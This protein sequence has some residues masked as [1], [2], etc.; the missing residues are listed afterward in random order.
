MSFETNRGY[1]PEE[2]EE[3]M[4]MGESE[5]WDET[6]DTVT[7]LRLTDQNEEVISELKS[8]LSEWENY[9]NISDK[10]EDWNELLAELKEKVIDKLATDDEDDLEV[11]VAEWPDISRKLELLK[12]KSVH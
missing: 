11:A 9:Y 12:K 2:D 3:T 7:G 6:L 5:I 8:K 1:N 4:E 10:R